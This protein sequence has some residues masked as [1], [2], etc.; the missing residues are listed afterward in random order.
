MSRVEQALRRAGQ[1]ATLPSNDE[2]SLE[3]YPSEPETA[4]A[5]ITRPTPAP[6]REPVSFDEF[7]ANDGDLRVA[8]TH[9]TKIVTSGEVGPATIEQYR[10]LAASLHQ[11][12]GEQGLRS[13]MVTSAVPQEG[14]T[15]TIVNLAVTLSESYKRRVLLIDADLRRP[16][17]HSV[18][19]LSNRRGLCDVLRSASGEVPFTRLSSHLAV[20]PAGSAEGD[21][22]SALAS[23]RI[24][25]LLED[26][27]SE[28]EWVLLDAPPVALMAD[29]RLLVRLTRAVIFV[30]GSGSTPYTAVE[31]AVAEIGR[32]HIIGTVLNRADERAVPLSP[33]YHSYPYGAPGHGQGASSFPA[34]NK[35]D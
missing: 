29:A 4:V 32:E 21:P 26:A 31:K 3:L 16:S 6:R 33:Y 2:P 27:A 9:K 12:Q 30:I 17:V 20:L 28:F 10:R 34:A 35:V 15:L 24:P 23:P 18:F 13:V 25:D 14:K 22:M 11:L 5:S 19:G 8:D 7:R 1:A